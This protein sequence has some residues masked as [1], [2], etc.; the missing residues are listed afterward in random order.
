MERGVEKL[1]VSSLD[2]K[3]LATFGTVGFTTVFARAL[4]WT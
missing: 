2:K 1:I 4:Y 3:F